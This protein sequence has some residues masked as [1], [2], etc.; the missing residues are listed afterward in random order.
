M[1]YPLSFATLAA[2]P[3][4]ARIDISGILQHVMV[5]GIE[6]SD[7]FLED[8]DKTLF[9]ERLSKLIIATGTECLTWS[10]ME[11]NGKSFPKHEA[12]SAILQTAY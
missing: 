9:V 7:I 4:T 5:R 11:A 2:M 3:R 6:K 8:D 1:R 12:S 10:L